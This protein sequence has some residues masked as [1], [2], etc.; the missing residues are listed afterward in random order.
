MKQHN[1]LISLQAIYRFG[2][3]TSIPPAGKEVSFA[4]IA[5]KSGVEEQMVRRILRHA[6]AHHI[7]Q[8][9]R[10][11]FITHTAASEILASNSELRQW[12]GMITEEMWPAATRACFL[13]TCSPTADNVY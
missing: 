1:S 5:S 3:A 10:S 9:P 7:F 4:E 13:Q 8:E 12:V 11:G 2:L 6:A